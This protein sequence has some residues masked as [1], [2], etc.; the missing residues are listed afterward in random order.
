MILDEVAKLITDNTTTKVAATSL[1]TAFNHP[2]APETATFIYETQGV[3]PTRTFGS[4]DPAFENPG[5]QIIDRSSDYDVAR[6]SAEIIY[7]LLDRQANTTLLPAAGTTGTFYLTIS[8]QQSP[9]SIGQ[10][11][12]GLH[13]ISHNYLI[14][15]EL[16]T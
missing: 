15:K 16:S 10:D 13:Q 4:S 14:S 5:I 1:F 2:E 7:K 11:D 8:A 9:F 12:N 3:P 6:N